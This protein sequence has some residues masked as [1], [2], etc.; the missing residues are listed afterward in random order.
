MPRVITSTQRAEVDI[1][2]PKKDMPKAW[3]KYFYAVRLKLASENETI[4]NHP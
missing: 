3:L 4:L 2:K 1:P